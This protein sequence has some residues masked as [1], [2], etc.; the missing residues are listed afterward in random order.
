M[1]GALAT[2]VTL[3]ALAPV[4]AGQV[5]P[6]GTNDP[7]GFRDVLPPGTNGH[8]TTPEIT[9]FLAG[10]DRP[11]HNADQR[12]MYGDLVY[13]APGLE[14][15]DLDRFFKD[16][17]FG[18]KEGEVAR[19][20]QPGG[21]DDVTVQRDR[22]FGVPH[23]YGATR[24]GLMFGLGYVTA[25]DRL[26]FTD[27]LRHAGRAQLSSFAG[28]AEGNR[29]MD[30]GV[31]AD[32][33]YTEDDLQRQVDQFDDLYGAEGTAL[34]RD[35]E[36]YVAGINAYIAEAQLN[37]NLMP[38]EYALLGHP[39]GP[40]PWKVTD[41]VAIA[42]L[43]GGI[44]GKGGGG[45]LGSA[46]L[47]T[48]FV[49]RFGK[50]RGRRM[51]RDFRSKEDPEAVTTVTGQ[52]FP[53]LGTPRRPRG[54]AIPDAGTLE[55]SEVL[56]GS[57]G[58][59]GGT[60]RAGGLLG[61]L[62]PASA[63]NALVVS[64]EEAEAGRPILVAGPQVSYFTPQ[65]LME[66]DAH[67]PGMDA[68]GAAFPGTNLFVQ[69]GRGRDYSWSATSAGNDNV[70]TFALPLCDD[71]SYRFRGECEE[72]EVLERTNTWSPSPGDQTPPGSETLR[73]ERTKMGIVTGRGE[74]DGKPVLFT[75]L[76]STYFHEVDSAVG[77]ARINDPA[78]IQGPRDFQQA[79]AR[80]G[81]TFNWLYAD[82]EDIAYFNSGNNPVRH[83]RVDPSFPA[84]AKYE[85]RDY[86]PD[87]WTARFTPF[88][89]HART[90][91][92]RFIQ[93]WNN[94]QAPGVEAADNR[95]NYGPVDRGQLLA[96]RLRRGTRG[97]RKMSVV[98]VV[99]AMEDAGTVDLRGD[100][101][102]P[103]ALRVLGRPKAEGLRDAIAKLRAWRK[104]GS[105]RRDRDRD[106][107][108]EHADAIAIMDAWWPRL[109]KAQFSRVLGDELA[110]R[111]I[112]F[113]GLGD[114]PH[115]H[116]GSAFDDGIWGQVQKD[117]RTLVGAPVRGRYSRVYCGAGSRKRCRADLTAAL[118]TALAIP[119]EE[120]YSGDG[121]DVGDQ[122]CW[123]EVRFRVVGGIT[124]PPI[125]WINRPT[126]QQVV[127]VQ[128]PAPR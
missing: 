25:E 79:F 13:A 127:Q 89:Q 9:A 18:V 54:R 69:L 85:W 50:R 52:R 20:Y 3:L 95:Y 70:D 100:K 123:D 32:T 33:P 99:D 41:V 38:G 45:E 111:V 126:Y 35:V 68:R 66:Q 51:W 36:A 84:F 80:V 4:A 12:D 116:Q 78:Q 107:A 14:P 62:F 77:F 17:T 34:T 81:Y 48:E 2:L 87:A 82:D 47:Y 55:R 71:T 106:G 65:I 121:C 102:L 112:S 53:Y 97:A 29:A 98:E 96:D 8:A 90:I 60:V 11:T 88:E 103:W 26:F 120:L 73:A 74:V 39:G 43:V 75:T 104:D 40:E 117:L 23:V 63:S 27:A 19:E 91:N 124:Q 10:G 105:H 56:A 7:G 15:G 5:Q 118:R 110:G 61:G 16:A 108:Y 49:K 76:R 58:A 125:H 109:V 46:E 72:I 113:I 42:S 37:P 114:M 31:W 6:Y 92:Q 44:F 1:K 24:E 28:G 122:I 93:S 94:K 59:G 22:A 67:G 128:G 30:R 64:A 83:P 119:R 57:G 86:D 115:I 21:R 101:V